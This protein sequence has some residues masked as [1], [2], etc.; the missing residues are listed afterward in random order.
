MQSELDEI[1]LEITKRIYKLFLEKFN[2]NKLAFA[3]AAKCDEKTIRRLF[4]NKQGMT[5]NLLSK[6]SFALKIKPSYLIENL[7]ITVKD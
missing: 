2:G 6:I 5:I 3:K 4:D 7:S 1:Q